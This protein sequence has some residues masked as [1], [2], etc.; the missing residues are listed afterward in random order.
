MADTESSPVS[1][2]STG[3]KVMLWTGR[4]ISALV[5]AMLGLSAVMK[6]TNS[7]QLNE[8]MAHL[9][10]PTKFAVALGITELVCTIVYAIP[11]TSV[12]GAILLTGYMG[13]TIATHARL[14]EAFFVQAGIGVLIWLG[15]F[16]RDA[17]LRA[18]I[19]L[20]R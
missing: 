14:E 17:R 2:G 13:G 12:L 16:L 19:P 3:V 5:V 6:F 20:R 7:P 8:G 1:T 11:Q 4:V 15:L 18:L 10:W 9:G